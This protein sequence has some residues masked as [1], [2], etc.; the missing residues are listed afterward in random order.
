M[1]PP[2]FRYP[3]S[4]FRAYIWLRLSFKRPASSLTVNRVISASQGAG[5]SDPSLLGPRG[6]IGDNWKSFDPDL[7]PHRLLHHY[8][9]R[10]P[11]CSS[12]FRYLFV[13][14]ASSVQ[15]GV[16]PV[17][18]LLYWIAAVGFP[19][20]MSVADVSDCLLDGHLA[21]LVT[22]CGKLAAVTHKLPNRIGRR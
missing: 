21:I 5:P 8:F 14:P 20:S 12:L 1:A 10:N 18:G 22:A 13:S 19:H 3:I 4:S 7:L 6:L 11:A 15:R 9:Q 16:S 17:S 2:I